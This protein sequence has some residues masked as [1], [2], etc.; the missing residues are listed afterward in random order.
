MVQTSIKTS[1]IVPTVPQGPQYHTNYLTT[2]SNMFKPVIPFIQM[3]Y[4]LGFLAG[5]LG[6]NVAMEGSKVAEKQYSEPFS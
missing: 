2:F 3:V 1:P 4:G 6:P 5:V